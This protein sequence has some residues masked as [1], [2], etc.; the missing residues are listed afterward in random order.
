MSGFNQRSGDEPAAPIFILGAD[1]PAGT[2]LTA[3]LDAHPRLSYTPASA[4][5]TDLL[6]SVERN[7]DGLVHYGLPQQYWLCSVARYFEDLQ[8]QH[9]ARMG[10]ARWV[11]CPPGLIV[12]LL[13]RAFPTAQ[14]VH[15]VGRNHSFRP[16]WLTVRAARRAGNRLAPGRYLEIDSKEILARPEVCL[17]RVLDFLGEP[18]AGRLPLPAGSPHFIDL[19]VKSAAKAAPAAGPR[20]LDRP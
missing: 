17:R 10:K 1:H 8:R 13:D 7:R 3:L 20:E 9:A 4:L 12:D 15:V 11:H 2:R 14:I 16:G 18:W 19:T 6:A 5:L